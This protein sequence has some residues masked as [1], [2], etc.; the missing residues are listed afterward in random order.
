MNSNRPGKSPARKKSPAN[1]WRYSETQ[2]QAQA[3][4]LANRVAKNLKHR[5]K[6]F[7]KQNVDAFRVYNQD[8]PEIRATVDW[9]A[10][11]LVV[12][13]YKRWQTEGI[14]WLPTMAAALSQKLDI[15]PQ[16]IH[17]KQRQ[18]RPKSGAQR[19]RRLQKSEQYRQVQEGDLRF[20]VNLDDYIDTGLF[21]DHRKARLMIAKMVSGQ[22]FLNLFA[23]TGAF[24]CHAAH[25]GAKQSLTVDLSANYIDWARRNMELNQ[26]SAEE[27]QFLV[28]DCLQFIEQESKR[29]P[30]S[31]DLIVLDPPSYAKRGQAIDFEILRD[32]ADLITK[33]GHL[34]SPQ[35]QLLF[36][37]NHQAFVLERQR[38]G[39]LHI[40]EISQQTESLDFRGPRR[41]HRSFL[42]RH[43]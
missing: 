26:L 36:S 2:V 16:N 37:T 38:L 18:T 10:G 4:M 8:I 23:Y 15:A 43:S 7:R 34:L 27:H 28:A 42:I 30:R 35:G 33:C 14:A 31:W 11:H 29:N 25:G 21:L 19:Y 12:A 9:Y 5:Y 3:Q 32:H 39:H 24:T 1:H 20:L 22:R 41:A 13:E 40:E 6:I 17:L